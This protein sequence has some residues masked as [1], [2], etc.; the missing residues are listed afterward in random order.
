MAVAQLVDLVKIV[1]ANTGTGPFT[2]GAAATGF[3]GVE[4]LTDGFTYS[5]S[6]QE[7]ANFEYGTGVYSLAGGTLTRGV[8]GSSY[9]G[10]P[11]NLPPNAEIAFV[12]LAQDINADNANDA[13]LSSRNLDDLA[14]VPT[15]RFNLG[16]VPGADVQAYDDGLQAISELATALYGRSLLTLANAAALANAAGANRKA[17]AFQIVGTAP[18]ASELLFAFTPP[19]GETWTFADDFAGFAFAKASTGANPAAPYAMDVKR[20]GV[21]VG[22]FEISAAGVVT[23]STAG[24]GFSLAGGTNWIEVFG[25]ATPDAGAVGYTV[26]LAATAT[27]A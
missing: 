13:L 19:A 2:L 5:Y 18:T 15:A 25:N 17:V 11:I 1:A 23:G 20:D 7:G 22:T 12:A 4:A 8:L 24:G 16:L 3:R 21:T 14:S 9:G 10:S 27:W 26:T 6:V